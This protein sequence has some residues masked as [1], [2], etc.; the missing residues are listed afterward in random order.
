MTT[1]H[2]QKQG[3]LEKQHTAKEI[4]VGSSSLLGL[5]VRLMGEAL[6]KH[7]PLTLHRREPCFSHSN[8]PKEMLVSRQG[9]RTLVGK[10]K[11]TLFSTYMHT[12]KSR[13]DIKEFEC[14]IAFQACW[15][16]FHGQAW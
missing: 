1:L 14:Q 13:G 5:C 12:M 3:L 6:S 7:Q 10:L 9:C 2:L 15:L 11:I 16:S 8:V 4:N